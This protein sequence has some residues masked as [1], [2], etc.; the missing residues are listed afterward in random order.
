MKA[1]ALFKTLGLFFK[2]NAPTI[3]TVASVV[4]STG[5][6]IA[7]VPATVKTVRKCDEFEYKN[8]VKPKAKD[9]IKLGWKYFIIPITLE[10]ASIACAICSNV[11]SSKRIAALAAAYVASEEKLENVRK[12]LLDKLGA[13][14]AT[15][16]LSGAEQREVDEENDWHEPYPE[17]EMIPENMPEHLF[18]YRDSFSGR[19]FRA[20]RVMIEKAVIDV[21]KLLNCD[22]YVTLN[23]F[24][25][26]LLLEG[27]IGDLSETDKGREF[28]WGPRTDNMIIV[29][30]DTY[31]TAP[32]GEAAIV[33]NYNIAPFRAQ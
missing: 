22:D 14:K 6:I 26:R 27:A 33:L 24:W 3:L 7:T 16:L 30:P 12:E 13:E 11:E 21:N 28:G 9:V 20:N 8:G 31:V 2:K 25:D 1:K 15:D 23:E 29:K 32:T 4:T 17:N 10:G 5:A 19:W 18:L